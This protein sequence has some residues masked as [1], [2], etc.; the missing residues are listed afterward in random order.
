MYVFNR[1]SNL[2]LFFLTESQETIRF[3]NGI[4]CGNGDFS[5]FSKVVE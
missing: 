5:I 3:K 2:I 4:K 1:V